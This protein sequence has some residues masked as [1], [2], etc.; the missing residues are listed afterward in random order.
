MA[1]CQKC[2]HRFSAQ[3]RLPSICPRCGASRESAAP[4]GDRSLETGGE[5]DAWVSIARL[6]NLAEVGYFADVL[7]GE[8]IPTQVTQHQEFN[9]LD[10]SWQMLFVLQVP[11][12]Q[13]VEAARRLHQAVD[14]SADDA[15][16]SQA[17]GGLLGA[18]ARQHKYVTTSAFWKPMV[19]VLI[20][21]GLFYTTRHVPRLGANP[22]RPR[23]SLWDALIETDQAFH[24]EAAPG[25]PARRLVPDPQSRTV[26]LYEDFNGDGRADR[27]RCFREGHL[28]RELNR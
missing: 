22:P 6:T 26:W 3:E 19:F 11:A 14:Q 18:L 27:A 12:L 17:G 7:E 8:G 5:P 15:A 13:A 23:P 9:A 16:D 1:R 4:A 10:G 24:G 21:G 20:A 28:I 25:Q 2:Q